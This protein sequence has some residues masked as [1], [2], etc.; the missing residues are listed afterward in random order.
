MIYIQAIG[1]RYLLIQKNKITS[2]GK[3]TELAVIYKNR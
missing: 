2:S 3:V 1:I